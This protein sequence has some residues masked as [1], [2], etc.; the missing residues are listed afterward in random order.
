[1]LKRAI[2]TRF[3]RNCDA[4]ITIG[5]NNE[6]YYRHYGVPEERLF[7]GAYPIDV[8]RF[9]QTLQDP[10]G[11][12][13]MRRGYD[14]SADD[15]VVVALGKLERRKRPRDLIEALSI[16]GRDANI[17]A[18]FVG[19]GSER[20][21]I[22]QLARRRGVENRIRITGFINQRDIPRVLQAGDLLAVM[23]E[24]D[25]H[26]LA[27]TEGLAVGYPVVVSDR[28]GCVGPT[29]TARPGVNAIVYP[30]GDVLQLARAISQV[31]GNEALRR[32]MAEA[33]R[34]IVW[35]Q[36]VS[37]AVRAVLNIITTLRPQFAGA[38]SDVSDEDFTQIAG[39][40]RR[41]ALKRA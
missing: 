27:V 20:E 3:Y 36:D 34:A 10:D 14:F 22:L 25:P 16:L 2:L 17:R 29:D 9:C 28:V 12:V 38:W 31:S 39:E 1:M 11:R 19:D 15:F 23:S 7:R 18:L 37:V 4:F 8:G 32:T 21:A 30:T 33:S 5:D 13:A 41:L 26:P 35:T 40:R 6:A 24:C